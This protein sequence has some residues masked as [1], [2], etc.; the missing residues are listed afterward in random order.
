MGFI[1]KHAL[2]TALGI[3]LAIILGYF[4]YLERVDAPADTAPPASPEKQQQ[5][6]A[7]QAQAQTQELQTPKI[8]QGD[9][10]PEA[11]R[12]I[13]CETCAHITDPESQHQCLA[14]FQCGEIPHTQ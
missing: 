11:K 6:P 4:V 8:P 2:A 12:A 14:T 10:S 3:S 9:I 1:Q 13:Q 5:V 7:E